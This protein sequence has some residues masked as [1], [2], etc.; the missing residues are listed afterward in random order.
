VVAAIIE[1]SVQ[2]GMAKEPDRFWW[3]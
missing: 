3:L 2:V 1:S